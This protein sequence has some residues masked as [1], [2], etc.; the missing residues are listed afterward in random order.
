MTVRLV[1]SRLSL[2]RAA[3]ELGRPG[4]GGLVVFA[5]RVRPDRT[6]DGRVTAL[7]YE[8]DRRP[9][10]DGLRALE[11][12][13]RR[14]FGATR[15]VLW[16]RVGRVPVGELAVIVGAACGHRDRA[17]AAARLLIDEIKRSVP[18]WKEVRARP[19][20]RPRRPRARPVAR[21]TG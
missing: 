18:I 14:R 15:L 21:S 3:S 7:V 6:R 13:V 8:V 9:A 11:R 4:V 17:F 5:G 19:G 10:I 16:H 12:T 20:R 1:R 2:A